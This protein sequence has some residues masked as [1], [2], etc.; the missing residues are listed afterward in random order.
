MPTKHVANAKHY[1]SRDAKVTAS[2][3]SSQPEQWLPSE[4][5][6][7]NPGEGRK[8]PDTAE[9]HEEWCSLWAAARQI[10]KGL[11]MELLC[12]PGIP[13]LGTF[14]EKLGMCVHPERLVH[15]HLAQSQNRNAIISSVGNNMWPSRV[16]WSLTVEGSSCCSHGNMAD[17]KCCAR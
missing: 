12:G 2:H 5:E 11:T 1:H 8:A 6:K 16:A 17:S 13:P 9:R 7:G 14:K 3:L 4:G 10:F 15:K